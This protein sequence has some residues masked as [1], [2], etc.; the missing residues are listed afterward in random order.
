MVLGATYAF[1]VLVCGPVTGGALNPARAFGLQVTSGHW[2]YWWV[3]WVGPLAGAAAA[4]LLY[5]FLYL[6]RNPP[7][8]L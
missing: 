1:G 3:Y 6:E 2:S 8:R 5:E 4:F 7:E